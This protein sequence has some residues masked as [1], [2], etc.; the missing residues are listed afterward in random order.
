MRCNKYYIVN[1]LFY[2]T[3]QAYY[4]HYV[5]MFSKHSLVLIKEVN[6]SVFLEQGILFIQIM[7]CLLSNLPRV[8]Q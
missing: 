5:A 2:A 3:G 4:L 1:N 7:L 6:V 8:L